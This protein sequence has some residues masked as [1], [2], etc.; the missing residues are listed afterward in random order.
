MKINIEMKES[1]AINHQMYVIRLA[2][3]FFINFVDFECSILYV[4]YKFSV[5]AMIF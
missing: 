2:P 5:E 4:S 3:N 1:S